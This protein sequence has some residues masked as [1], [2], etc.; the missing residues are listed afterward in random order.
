MEI[1]VSVDFSS[2]FLLLVCDQ[3]FGI[4]S[5]FKFCIYFQNNFKE[6]FSVLN[7]FLNYSAIIIP[8]NKN[9]YSISKYSVYLTQLLSFTNYERFFF[10]FCLLASF[11][12]LAPIWYLMLYFFMFFLVCCFHDI[13][14]FLENKGQSFY[15]IIFGWILYDT[16][17]RWSETLN[18]HKSLVPELRLLK[19]GK[20]HVH[21]W[22][23]L[24]Q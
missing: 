1:N 15:L 17:S 8:S 18:W 5:T 4:I 13:N 3:H 19:H 12:V 20:F 21:I 14:T 24:T 22:P 7:I 16:S 11:L 2:H 9:Y 23:V 6:L 10:W